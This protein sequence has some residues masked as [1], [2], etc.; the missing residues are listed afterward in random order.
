LFYHHA[1]E[2]GTPSI[3]WKGGWP[4]PR[5]DVDEVMKRKLLPCWNLNP[6]FPAYSQSVCRL[7]YPDPVLN[8]E[9]CRKYEFKIFV[10]IAAF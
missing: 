10:N 1:A 4:S 3:D 9:T 2:E 6:T 5:T 8:T 7:S